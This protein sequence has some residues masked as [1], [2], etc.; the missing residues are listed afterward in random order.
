MIRSVTAG[1][2]VG[3]S[4]AFAACAQGLPENIVHATLRDGWRTESG[5]QMAALHLTLAPGWKTY[6]RAPGEGGIPPSFDWTGS[7]NIGAVTFHWPKP[8][9]FDLNGMRTIG[10]RGELVLPIEFRPDVAGKPVSVSARIDFGVCDE[11][12]V[13]VAV[14]VAADLSAAETPDPLIRAALDQMPES[15]PAA[16]LSAAR[17]AAEPIRDGLRLTSR[18]TL[19]RVGPDEFAV[20]ELADQSVWVSPADTSRDGADL[21]ATADLVPANAKPFALDRST[22]R[23]TVFGGSGR[24]VDIQGCTG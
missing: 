21:N 14:D 16:G 5:T 8:E 6:W 1:T 13:P 7:E 15:G 18:L 20:V 9:V 11:I 24:V 3:L 22:V 17:C 4:A 19:P 10:Y 23:I 2:L 12:C